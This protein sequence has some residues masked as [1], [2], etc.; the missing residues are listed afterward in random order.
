MKPASPPVF[1][2]LQP[3][4]PIFPPL[5]YL[6]TKFYKREMKANFE[7]TLRKVFLTK[8]TQALGLSVSFS[9]SPLSGWHSL[10]LLELLCGHKAVKHED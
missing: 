1:T 3:H 2:L 9:S 6:E 8:S 4:A 5:F 7:G 10:Q